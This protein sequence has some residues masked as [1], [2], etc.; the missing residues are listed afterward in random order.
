MTKLVE[1][2]Y[3]PL[4]VFIPVVLVCLLYGFT[5]MTIDRIRGEHISA[6][7]T[8]ALVNALITLL[9]GMLAA[10]LAMRFGRMSSQIAGVR[11]GDFMVLDEEAAPE[12][13]SK[14]GL[15]G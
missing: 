2:I 6:S 14:S 3:R 1:N 12:E 5:K 9:I 7:A 13:Q 8:L 4:R 10:A 11:A 15:S